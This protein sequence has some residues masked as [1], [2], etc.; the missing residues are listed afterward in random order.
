MGKKKTKNNSKT[1]ET[2]SVELPE[3]EEVREL[4]KSMPKSVEKKSEWF[5]V[6]MC[7]INKWQ[8]YVGFEEGSKPEPDH[9]P[10]PIDNTDIIRSYF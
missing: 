3:A 8:T 5:V 2:E 1:E 4:I 9:P 10:G 6:S 7:W